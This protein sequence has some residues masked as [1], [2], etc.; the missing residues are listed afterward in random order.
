MNLRSQGGLQQVLVI[1]THG[2]VQQCAD[3]G[4]VRGSG[5]VA[6]LELGQNGCF[7]FRG[8]DVTYPWSMT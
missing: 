2:A 1:E 8:N 5:I 7:L 3:I 6:R 4:Q